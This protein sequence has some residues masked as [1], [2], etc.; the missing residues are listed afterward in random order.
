MP[1]I[2]SIDLIA[3]R[4]KKRK[5]DD[6]IIKGWNVHYQTLQEVEEEALLKKEKAEKEKARREEAEKEA[7]GRK[8]AEREDLGQDAREDGVAE[9]GQDGLEQSEKAYNKKTGA[10]SGHYGKKPVQ[11]EEAKNKINA[12]LTE[13]PDAYSSAMS[14]IQEQEGK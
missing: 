5:M 3:K 11:D 8:E 14:K 1:A 7:A 13:K 10:Y 12:I 6:S 2:Y 4:D 9:D